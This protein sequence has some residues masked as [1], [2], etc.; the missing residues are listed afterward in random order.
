M[1]DMF[2]HIS[3][4]LRAA[5]ELAQK[6]GFFSNTAEEKILYSGMQKIESVYRI[7]ALDKSLSL[8]MIPSQPVFRIRLFT[9]GAKPT[10]HR[11]L[12]KYGLPQI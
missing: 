5:Y 12:E 9:K 6:M 7:D 4:L 3:L 2:G 8:N 1:L 11:Q 10:D